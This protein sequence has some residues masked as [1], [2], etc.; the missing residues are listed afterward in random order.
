MDRATFKPYVKRTARGLSRTNPIE[1][2]YVSKY[3]GPKERGESARR[4]RLAASKALGFLRRIEHSPEMTLLHE[5]E[6]PDDRERLVRPAGAVDADDE[7][8]L[9]VVEEG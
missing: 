1:E 5:S 3:E 8:L 7:T 4:V 2:R 6:P 9:R